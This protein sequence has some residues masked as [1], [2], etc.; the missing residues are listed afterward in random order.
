MN[1]K[2]QKAYELSEEILENLEMQTEKVSTILLKVLRL[3]RL[4]NDIESMEWL[5]NE[6]GG[7]KNIKPRMLSHKDYEIAKK[8]GRS[9]ID[10]DGKEYVFSDTI[11]ELE[12][13]IEAIKDSVNN[14]TTQGVSLAGEW[15]HVGMANLTNSVSK[16][17][18][19]VIQRIE[20]YS[21]KIG[22]L[23]GEY[24]K[25]VLSINME[26]GFSKS[27]EDIFG[28]YRD[29]VDTKLATIIGDRD[30]KLSAIYDRLEESNKES[31][32]QAADTCRKLFKSVADSLF[33]KMYP[34]NKEK[35]IKV[36]SGQNV[37]ISGDKYVNRLTV[38][39]DKIDKLSNKHILDTIAWI[40][41]VNDKICDGLHNDITYQEIQQI[42]IHTY[43]CLGDI[44]IYVNAENKKSE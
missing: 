24:Y 4:T 27:A 29:I 16:H 30:E 12:N 39:I 38:C 5:N 8:Y 36:K 32:S 35:I 22:I 41:S 21:K 10:E 34:Q 1:Q 2:L 25:Y 11:I 26:L 14:V 7:Y 42:I 44:L 15:A 17:S 43:I 28:K 3:A 37:D 20:R 40:S 31:W 18:S 23:K 13:K 33:E 9:Y 6:I 19:D